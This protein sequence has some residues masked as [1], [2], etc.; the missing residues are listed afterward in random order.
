[1]RERY[2]DSKAQALSFAHLLK[3]SGV[4]RKE[5]LLMEVDEKDSIVFV[6]GILSAVSVMDIPIQNQNAIDSQFN[7]LFCCNRNVVENAKT[8]SFIGWSMMSGWAKERKS[9]G[10]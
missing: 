4:S 9:I 3:E 6:E 1:M 2:V 7:C 5:I 8:H 10:I